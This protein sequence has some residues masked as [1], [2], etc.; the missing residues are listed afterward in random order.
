MLFVGCE[1]PDWVGRFLLRMSSNDRLLSRGQAVLLRSAPR[2]RTNRRCR[3]SLKRIAVSR[4]SSSWRWSRARSLQSC[5]H[6]G[7]RRGHWIEATP[8]RFCVADTPTIFISYMR[9]DADAAERLCNAI[10]GELGGDVW[11]DERRLRPGDAWEREILT[12]IRRTVRLFVPIIS[13]NTERAEEGYVFREWREAVDRS[14][15]IMGRRF[16]VPVIVDDGLRGRP[17]S[18]P[19][20]AR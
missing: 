12:A 2:P 17:E 1:I 11:L 18:V 15:S 4:R 16:I 13:A 20:D 3:T 10:S 6:A 5:V 9:E 19:A 8:C 7:R 14:L